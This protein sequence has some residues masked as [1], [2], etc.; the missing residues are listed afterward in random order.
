MS[1]HAMLQSVLQSLRTRTSPRRPTSTTVVQSLL[2]SMATPR[3]P[4]H[5]TRTARPSF[6]PYEGLTLHQARQVITQ[7]VIEDGVLSADDVQTILTRKVQAAKTAACW[8]I[9]R[10]KT[11][12]SNWAAS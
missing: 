10:W 2:N 11:T 4:A 3:W 7:C 5:R 1:Y 6:A 8:N 12:G 9:I